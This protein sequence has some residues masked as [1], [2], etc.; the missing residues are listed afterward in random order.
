MCWN[1]G[2][3]KGISGH[4]V[5]LRALDWRRQLQEL[6]SESQREFYSEF[7]TKWHNHLDTCHGSCVLK[8]PDL[9][10]IV[11][12]SFLKFDEEHY[13]LTDFVVMPNHVDLLAAFRDEESM[14]KQ[15]ERW[16][17]FQAVQINRAINSSGR[18]WQQDGFDHPVRYRLA[19]RWTGWTPRTM[20]ASVPQSSR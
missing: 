11:A 4:A 7:S 2:G 14:L 3:S 13:E 19:R 8:T 5:N 12:D 20:I 17:C 1:Y 9:A 6:A 16:K 10:Q 15:C 18:F